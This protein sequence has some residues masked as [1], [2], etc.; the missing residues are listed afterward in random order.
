MLF[1]SGILENVKKKWGGF[2]AKTQRISRKDAKEGRLQA[3]SFK[4]QAGFPWK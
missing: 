3:A 4:L 1:L 2:H